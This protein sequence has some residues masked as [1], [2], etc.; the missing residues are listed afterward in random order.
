MEIK[1]ITD[2]F[3]ELWQSCWFKMLVAGIVAF[4]AGAILL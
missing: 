4:V 2:K 3:N 1:T